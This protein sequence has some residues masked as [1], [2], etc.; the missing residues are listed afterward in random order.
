VYK[1]IATTLTALFLGTGQE[2]IFQFLS[3][4]LWIRFWGAGLYSEWLLLSL[5]PT[6]LLRGNTGVFHSATSE[7][8]MLFRQADFARAAATLSVLRDAQNL[9]LAGVVA[10][11]ILLA[12]TV[13]MLLEPVHFDNP[14]L[15]LI[16]LLFSAQFALFQW[17]Q[18]S[19]SLAK[20]DGQASAAI[21]WQN[22]FR[23][24]FML[25]MLGGSPLYGPVPCA[26]VGITGQ[27]A[28]ALATR[29]RFR[30]IGQ[31]LGTGSGSIARMDVRALTIRGVQ[32]SLFPFGQTAAHTA[33][34][35]A[36]G[37]FFGPLAGAAFHNMRT[38]SRIVVLIARAVE[39]AIRLELS[40]LFA[41]ADAVRSE[42]LLGHALAAAGTVCTAASAVLLV[43]GQ[44][45]FAFITHGE[46]AFHQTAFVIL[47]AGALAYAMS[48]I[49]MSVAFALNRQGRIAEHYLVT[50]VVLL[51]ATLPA[52]RLG[53]QVLACVILAAEAA[54]LLLARAHAVGLV[55][56][57]KAL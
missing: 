35:W 18:T 42:R 23:L 47:C 46:L 9:F 20:A 6:L 10:T 55:R 22:L 40:G 25:G 26:A 32:F 52:A 34:V 54:I 1:R 24:V 12:A 37:L 16:A 43:L 28:V 48:Q 11:Y 27:L 38:I 51:A 2:V 19:L 5:L 13:G 45:L 53:P 41:E 17:Q 21:Q 56:E 39:Q 49:Y 31:M 33:S 15:S 30:R 50:L 29:I 44:P 4:I 36:I 7:L 57:V 8:I 3:A 14:A